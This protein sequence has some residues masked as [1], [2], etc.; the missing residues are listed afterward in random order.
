VKGL[1]YTRHSLLWSGVMFTCGYTLPHR[2]DRVRHGL[3]SFVS[4]FYPI[5]AT[6]IYKSWCPGKLPCLPPFTT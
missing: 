3:V 1:T 2:F 4:L 6:R 5:S